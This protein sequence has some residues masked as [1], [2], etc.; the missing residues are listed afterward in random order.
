MDLQAKRALLRKISGSFAALA[1]HSR[2]VFLLTALS[3]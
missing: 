3:G 1:A 2:L